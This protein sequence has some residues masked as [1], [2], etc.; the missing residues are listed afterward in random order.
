MG[1]SVK[2]QVQPITFAQRGL[3]RLWVETGEKANS[4]DYV[5]LHSLVG[6]HNVEVYRDIQK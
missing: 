2:P 6:Y 1:I 3:K 5:L 4:M